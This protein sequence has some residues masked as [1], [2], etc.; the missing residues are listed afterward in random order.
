MG[1]KFPPKSIGSAKAIGATR[2][3]GK[4]S[5]MLAVI[6]VSIPFHG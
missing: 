5:Y 4:E 1:Q 2:D 3:S 6:E